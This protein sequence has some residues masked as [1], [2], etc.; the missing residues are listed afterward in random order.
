VRQ[1][2]TSR[3][4]PKTESPR[5]DRVSLSAVSVLQSGTK[6][7]NLGFRVQAI[8]SSMDTCHS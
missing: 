5:N 1:A 8:E 2:C 3:N 7:C 4:G 6:F